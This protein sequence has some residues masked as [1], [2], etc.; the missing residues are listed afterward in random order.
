MRKLSLIILYYFLFYGCTNK[1]T[2]NIKRDS[3][4]VADSSQINENKRVP[5]LFDEDSNLI[6]YTEYDDNNNLE[7][8]ILYSTIKND[9]GYGLYI[10]YDSSG[11]G[12]VVHVEVIAV[13]EVNKKGLV[14]R[15]SKRYM[16]KFFNDSIY[17]NWLNNMDKSKIIYSIDT[18]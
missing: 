10:V 7:F 18:Y 6:R 13:E 11:A 17:N 5:F 8:E 14:R 3:F 2:T 16:E 12:K 9:M 4:L 1:K 15:Y